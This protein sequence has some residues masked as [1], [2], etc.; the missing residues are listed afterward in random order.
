VKAYTKHPVGAH[1]GLLDWALQRITAVL[2]AIYTVALAGV[3]LACA[4]STHQEWRA[5]FTGSFMRLATV[6]AVAALLY[7]AW[8]GLRDILMDY[9]KPAYLRLS[10]QV[11]VA[12]VLLFYLVWSVSILWGGPRT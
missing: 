2:M 12:V 11:F 8:V 9:V 10:L 1:Y 7:H 6:L 4:P 5:L 3:V